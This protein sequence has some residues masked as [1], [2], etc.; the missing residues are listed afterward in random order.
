MSQDHCGKKLW[1]VQKH[2][3]L[4]KGISVFLD[5][6]FHMPEYVHVSVKKKTNNSVGVMN[7]IS[8]LAA[9]PRCFFTGV[10][11]PE[12]PDSKYFKPKYRKR[13]Q[14]AHKWIP[15]KS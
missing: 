4:R 11:I 7:S 5:Q 6:Y 12:A 3:V 8:D 2:F 9:F 13:L 15:F 10:M 14:K 1:Y